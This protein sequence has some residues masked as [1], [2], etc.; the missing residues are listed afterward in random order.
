LYDKTS[1]TLLVQESIFKFAEED[2]HDIVKEAYALNG[3]YFNLV[4]PPNEDPAYD[5]ITGVEW[6]LLDADFLAMR[7]FQ[8]L[9][10]SN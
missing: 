10:R 6:L 1:F 4:Q 5:A 3:T 8:Y 7:S 9:G 2:V